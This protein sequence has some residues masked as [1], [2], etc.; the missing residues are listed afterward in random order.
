MCSDGTLGRVVYKPSAVEIDCRIVGDSAIVNAISPDGYQQRASLAELINPYNPPRTRPGGFTSRPLPTYR[1]LPYNR[2][3]VPDAYGYIEFLAHEPSVEVHATDADG[4]RAEVGAKVAALDPAALKRSDWITE[5]PR[6]GQV[7]YHVFGG[8]MAM[9]MAVSLCDLHPQNIITHDRLPHL[10]DLEE[11]LKHPMPKAEDTYLTTVIDQVARAGSGE[12]EIQHERT[13]DLN[14]WNW[15]F[16]NEPAASLLYVRAGSHTRPEPALARDEPNRRALIHGF[17]DV[18][19]ALT[20]P[21]CH[22]EVK[23]WVGSLE[24]TIARFVTRS[25]R[26]YARAGRDMYQTYPENSPRALLNDS[27]YD[28][29]KTKD[30]TGQDQ[31]FFTGRVRGMRQIWNSNQEDAAADQAPW[32]LPLF[33]VEH[34]DHA[35]RDYLNGDVPSFYHRLGSLDLLNTKG[36]IVDV[37]DVIEW[38]DLTF[39]QQAGDLNEFCGR[40][41]SDGVFEKTVEIHHYFP[42]RPIDMAL[43]QLNRMMADCATSQGKR[44]F[45]QASLAGAGGTGRQVSEALW[46]RWA[47]ARGAPRAAAPA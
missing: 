35:W 4:I 30:A 13:S 8:L 18:I 16:P 25:T 33:A 27:G 2:D 28:A 5:E 44:K 15:K 24:R 36:D 20:I 47:Q 41:L 22:E 6:D 29:F 38:Q 23:A 46:S 9:A 43:A 37:A 42:E 19:E 39:H 1:I 10:I 7:F 34:P 40:P 21:A 45:L 11:A 12:L 3:S 17:I 32:I 14:L 31:F 26:E